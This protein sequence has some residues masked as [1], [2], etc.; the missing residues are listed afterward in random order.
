MKYDERITEQTYGYSWMKVLEKHLKYP[1]DTF[2]VNAPKM[3]V[4]TEEDQIEMEKF[5]F[6]RDLFI[7][8]GFVKPG[9]H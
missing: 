3:S 2:Y 5:C 6:N 8:A 1:N 4:Y 7:I 9:K